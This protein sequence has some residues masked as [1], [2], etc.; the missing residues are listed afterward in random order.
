M[1]MYINLYIYICVCVCLYVCVY[2]CVCNC[3]CAS[4]AKIR[5]FSDSDYF[6]GYGKNRRFCPYT[7]KYESEITHI[8]PYY[9]QYMLYS[10]VVS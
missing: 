9:T 6:S 10:Y 7:R 3:N 8:L 1:Y 4:C 5:V 2:L